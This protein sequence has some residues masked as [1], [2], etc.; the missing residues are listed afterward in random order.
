M[1][2][3]TVCSD[4][5]TAVAGAISSVMSDFSG[6]VQK[7]KRVEKGG[8]YTYASE[9]AFIDAVRPLIVKHGLVVQMVNMERECSDFT[10][11]YGAVMQVTRVRVVYRIVHAPSGEWLRYMTIGCGMDTGDK[12]DNKAMT[13]AYKYLWREMCITATGDDPDRE[14]L[15]DVRPDADHVPRPSG[16]PTVEATL[17]AMNDAD[18]DLCIGW[19]CRN[20]QKSP[21]PDV[22]R[23]D[24][25]ARAFVAR[26]AAVETVKPGAWLEEARRWRR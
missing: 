16:Q 24:A 11:K 23:Q 8:N 1:T 25:S 15:E 12:A 22:Y 14:R 4:S 13:G 9:A 6:Y 20:E 17:L 19:L 10:T 5:V 26:C 7:D 21:P 18:L 2:I 3:D